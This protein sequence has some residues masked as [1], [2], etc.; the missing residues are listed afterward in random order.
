MID[1][2]SFGLFL[3]IPKFRSVFSE[4]VKFE[5]ELFVPLSKVIDIERWRNFAVFR[6]LIFRLCTISIGFGIGELFVDHF[7][8]PREV[9]LDVG[10]VQ[11]IL[12]IF[13]WDIEQ[14]NQLRL[15]SAE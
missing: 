15:N 14:L 6:K 12:I 3:F 2:R 7:F 10:V 13:G 8:E 4:F 1:D 9:L 5:H 11:H